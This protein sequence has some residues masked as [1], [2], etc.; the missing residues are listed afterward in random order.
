MNLVD[1]EQVILTPTPGPEPRIN[2]PKRFGVRPGKPF[3]YRIPCTGQRPIQFKATDLPQGL[4][5]DATTGVITGNAPDMPKDYAMTFEASNDCGS[6]TRPFKI[7]VG[8]TLALTPPMGWNSWYIHYDRVT[9]QHM[10]QAADIMVSSGMADFGYMYVNIDDCWMKKRDDKP[11]RDDRGA[12]LPNSKFPDMKGM[13]DHIHAQGLR[14]GT[15]SSPGDWTCA[16]YVGSYQ[17]EEDDAKQYADWGFDF[18]KYD[19]CAYG[20][21]Y[22]RQVKQS[23]EALGERKIPYQKMGELLKKQNRDIVLNICQYGHGK[24]WEWGEEVGGH[25]WRTTEDLGLEGDEGMPAFFNVG[26]S[27]A[28]HPQHAKPGS[29]NDPDYLLVGWVG[30]A[31][32]M[33]EGIPTTLT[34]NEQYTYMSMWSLMAAPLFFS[35]DL[36]KLDPFT[37]NILCNSEVIDVNQDALGKQGEIIKKTEVL[38]IMAKPLEDG[39]LAVGLFNIGDTEQELTLDFSELGLNGSYVVRDLW[40]QKNLGTYEG[41]FASKIGKHGVTLVCLTPSLKEV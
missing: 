9:E 19:W 2:G 26:L 28:Q 35:G 27:N 22:D 37:L 30:D 21:I 5:L 14:A 1:E 34:P 38:S 6:A 16:D 41:S 4:T 17:H 23:Q 40:R 31:H 15:Y 25:C 11:Y 20:K 13:V 24:V 3:L 36:D 32:E 10:R 8:E 18:L 12:V 39:S 7:V 33:G 29:W